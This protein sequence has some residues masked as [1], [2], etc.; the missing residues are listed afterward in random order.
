MRLNIAKSPTGLCSARATKGGSVAS[1]SK[2]TSTDLD[3]TRRGY[4]RHRVLGA[5]AT[6]K[7]GTA[8][9]LQESGTA[10]CG[11]GRA[12]VRPAGNSFAKRAQPRDIADSNPRC[13]TT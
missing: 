12:R 5:F 3:G 2:S 4:H 7:A 11:A 6:P 9:R 1:A 8:A 13:E 10:K